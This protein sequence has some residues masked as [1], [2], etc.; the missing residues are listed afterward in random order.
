MRTVGIRERSQDDSGVEGGLS[1][2]K[3]DVALH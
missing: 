3:N 1:N 2:G